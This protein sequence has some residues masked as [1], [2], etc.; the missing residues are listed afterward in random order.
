MLPL[1]WKELMEE[2]M[3]H[4]ACTNATISRGSDGQ[5]HATLRG[6]SV[7]PEHPYDFEIPLARAEYL[8]DKSHKETMTGPCTVP[9]CKMSLSSVISVPTRRTRTGTGKHSV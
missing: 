5:H 2:E 7:R 1:P 9:K 3:F 4:E 8:H 6:A